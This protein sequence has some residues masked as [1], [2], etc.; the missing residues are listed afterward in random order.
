MR[1]LLPIAAAAVL[2]ASSL[3]GHAAGT[4]SLT[5]SGY[6]ESFDSMGT[7]GTATPTGW[8][9]YTGNSGTSNSTW[10]S[11]IT[12]NGSNSVASMVATSSGLTATTTP[13]GTKANG[14]NA[15]LSSASTSDRVLATSPT[16]IAGTA[17][18]LTLSN[19]TGSFVSG[20]TLSYDI[21]RYTTVSST[22]ELPG[23]WLFYSLDGTTWTNVSSLNST[24]AT[25][26]NSTGTSTVSG[27]ISFASAVAAG[28]TIYLRWV[29]D[30][31]QPTSPDQI[32]GLNNVS[33]SAISAVPEP[34]S[35]GLLLAGLA[36]MGAA[37]RRRLQSPR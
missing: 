20:L 31:G 29:D 2:L 15:A 13:S 35:A 19:D 25:V 32:L 5:T 18:Q 28:T 14:F 6:S 4:A 27:T 24:L 36:L 16:S 34:Q 3:S 23:Y 26:P 12:A 11:E 1:H 37:L 10:T 21:V 8:A 17:L 7:S 9:V 33:V 30:N 22:E